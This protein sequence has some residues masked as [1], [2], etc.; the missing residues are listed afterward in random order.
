MDVGRNKA[1]KRCAMARCLECEKA[2]TKTPMCLGVDLRIDIGV[3]LRRCTMFN[4]T[5]QHAWP[6]MVAELSA[7]SLSVVDHNCGAP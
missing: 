1:Q 6:G 2:G 3:R 4:M 7:N 5:D